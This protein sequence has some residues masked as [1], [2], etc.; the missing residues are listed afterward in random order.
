[1]GVF[2]YSLIKGPLI[3]GSTT[4]PMQQAYWPKGLHKL[5][6]QLFTGALGLAGLCFWQQGIS[7]LSFAANCFCTSGT[8]GCAAK[9]EK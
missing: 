8:R 6:Q 1:V 3:A 4:K 9:K 7:H 2:L 5:W